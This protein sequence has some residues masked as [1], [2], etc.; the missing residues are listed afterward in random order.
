METQ[1]IVTTA[2]ILTPAA[3]ATTVT[4]VITAIPI[5]ARSADTPRAT[6]IIL[7]G[8]HG[9][10]HPFD[11]T[12]PA[13]QNHTITPTRIPILILATQETYTNGTTAMTHGTLQ[14]H[15]IPER[16]AP[17]IHPPLEV[18]AAALACHMIVRIGIVT[19]TTLVQQR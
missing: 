1:A 17:G 2:I 10:A 5:L 3:M 15:C 13:V 9:T 12:A 11:Q 16:A 19:P 18:T 8:A 7:I 14:E 4:I 6:I